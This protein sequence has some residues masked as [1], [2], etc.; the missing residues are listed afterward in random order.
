MNFPHFSF[1]QLFLLFFSGLQS[2]TRNYYSALNNEFRVFA[3]LI[4]LLFSYHRIASYLLN[5]FIKS[6]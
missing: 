5:K 3:Y 4:Y 2:F 6:C 1:L